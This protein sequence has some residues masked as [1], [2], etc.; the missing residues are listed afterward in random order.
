MF[1]LGG[2]SYGKL[3]FVQLLHIMSNGRT[4][5]YCCSEGYKSPFDR[6]ALNSCYKPK[7]IRAVLYR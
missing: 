5:L 3:N 4:K 2:A 1:D 6:G 7:H